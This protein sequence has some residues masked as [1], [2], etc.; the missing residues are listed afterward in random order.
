MERELRPHHIMHVLPSRRGLLLARRAICWLAVACSSPLVSSAI[1][2]QTRSSPRRSTRR[3]PPRRPATRPVARPVVPPPATPRSAPE[4][5]AALGSSLDAGTRN[6]DWGVL[7]VSL[8]RGDTLFGR[9]ADRPLLP[10]STMKLF[11]AALALDRLGPDHRFS[12]DVLRD[13]EVGEDG[14]LRGALYLRGGG[15]PAFSNRYVRG[16]PDA[17]VAELARLVASTGIRRIRGD[18]VGDA[19]AFE[20]RTIPDGWKTTYLGASYAARVSALSLSENVVWVAVTPTSSGKNATVVLEPSSSAGIPVG[21][22]VRTTGGRGASVMARRNPDGSITVGGSIGLRAGTRRYGLVV[23][24]P[25]RF[26]A[27]A[28]RDAL[29]REGIAVEGALRLGRTPPNA[30]KVASHLS[31][32]LERLVSDMNRESINH[33]AELIFRNA[34]RDA[35]PDAPG[36]AE[37]GNALMQEV[38]AKT[39][40]PRG[41]AYAADGSG[42]STLDRI[43]GRAMIHLLSWSHA[44]AWGSAFHASLPVAGESELLRNRMRRT[45]AAGNLH[46]KTGTTNEVIGLA[47]YVTAANGEVLA[48]SFVYNGRDRSAA[49]TTIDRMGAEMA[50]F[51][52]D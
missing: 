41:S 17:P 22:R 3:T 30:S 52:R 31:P 27:G 29:I 8:T 23:E 4:L 44:A 18:I 35:R 42:L 7:V 48:F 36:S 1:E 39:G 43:S 20:S 13:A 26:T 14:T 10:A 11:T 12:T 9:N 47:G 38:L 32:P 37:S 15:D 2:A 6:G 50:A 40:A 21:G 19:S 34:A 33:F 24:D 5:A 46:A 28:F 51:I 49:R 16:T 45:P 25:A